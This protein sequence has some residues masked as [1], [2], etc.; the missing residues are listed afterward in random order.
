VASQATLLGHR[1]KKIAIV[2]ISE[3][4]SNLERLEQKIKK[5]TD[6]LLGSPT[7]TCTMISGGTDKNT[8]PSKCKLTIDSRV[9]PGESLQKRLKEI[10]DACSQRGT[11]TVEINVLGAKEATFTNAD[12]P[13]VVKLR[14]S[15]RT[16]LGKDAEPTGFPAG[17]DM[18]Y[19]VNEGHVPTVIF[20]PGSLDVA[21]KADE[22]VVIDDLINSALIYEDLAKRFLAAS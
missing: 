8:D 9:I 11:D 19:L 2:S 7:L 5:Q 20:G 10:R 15:I 18:R 16:I 21:H 22:F 1:W 14:E 6:K 3:I 4:V 13:I 12:S 17:C